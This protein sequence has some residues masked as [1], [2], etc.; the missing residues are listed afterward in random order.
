MSKNGYAFFTS[1][2]LGTFNAPDQC[3]WHSGLDCYSDNYFVPG[4]NVVRR[5]EINN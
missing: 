4:E 5:N 1:S 3:G 2:E